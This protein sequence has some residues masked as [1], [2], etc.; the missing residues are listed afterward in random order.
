MSKTVGTQPAPEWYRKK[1]GR[2]TI[3]GFTGRKLNKWSGEKENH[4][5][6]KCHCGRKIIA[7]E[8][9]LESGMVYSCPDCVALGPKIRSEEDPYR[10]Q[11]AQAN[12][13]TVCRL[14][15]Y[16]K[17]VPEWWWRC[18]NT[19][20]DQMVQMLGRGTYSDERVAE[21]FECPLEVVNIVRDT[22]PRQIKAVNQEYRRM[23][24]K[25]SYIQSIPSELIP[26]GHFD[27]ICRIAMAHTTKRDRGKHYGY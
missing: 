12:N 5:L 15:L 9:E 20:M 6:C 11:A 16:R 14:L 10:S 21:F 23:R 8:D 4:Y 19:V 1:V 26:L 7:T 18:I 24:D 17:E 22:Y 27:R 25:F 13:H 3:M 2:L